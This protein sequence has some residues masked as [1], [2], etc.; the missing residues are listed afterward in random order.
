MKKRSKRV[1]RK[2]RPVRRVNPRS[3]MRL[4][5]YAFGHSFGILSIIALVFYALMSWFAGYDP[6]IIYRQFPLRFSF[7]D[8]SIL[9]G[10]VQTYVISYIGGW[11]FVRIY[12]KVLRH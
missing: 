3:G 4:S 8:W 1:A 9:I 5:P 2:A 12:N 10:I 6:S 7:N 11:I